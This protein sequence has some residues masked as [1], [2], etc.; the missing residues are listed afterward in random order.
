MIYFFIYNRYEKQ[1]IEIDFRN[2][3]CTESISNT[4]VFDTNF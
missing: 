4:C 1:L 3:L 2:D